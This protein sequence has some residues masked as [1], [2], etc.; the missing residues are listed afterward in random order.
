[1][2]VQ[3]KYGMA[4]SLKFIMK[5]VIILDF[6]FDGVVVDFRGIYHFNAIG[7]GFMRKYSPDKP[8]RWG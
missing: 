8:W 5:I 7:N 3:I 6:S 2:I 4:N 1:M